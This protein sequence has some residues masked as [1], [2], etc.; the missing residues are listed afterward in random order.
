MFCSQC[1]HSNPENAAFC[2][3]C[4]NA[5]TQDTKI[6]TQPSHDPG[7]YNGP[8]YPQTAS[9]SPSAPP[10]NGYGPMPYSPPYKKKRTGLIAGLIVAALLV[11][12][13]VLFIWP[14]V[15]T[16]NAPDVTGY[17]YSDDRGETIELKS[18]GSV[19]VYTT[20]DSFRG[21]YAFDSAAGLGVITVDGID[22][23]FAMTKEGIKVDGM[24][25]YEKADD[26]FDVGGFIDD[27]HAKN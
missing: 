1:G 6:A 14:G 22:Y 5:L 15:V 20:D 8:V 18:S 4:G 19:R 11:A 17:W 16:A 12:A 26:D 7:A 10:P 27:M 21:R 24:G 13:V 25:V 9:F 23:E 3:A 2:T